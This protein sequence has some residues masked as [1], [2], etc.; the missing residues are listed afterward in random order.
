[1]NAGMAQIGLAK[2]RAKNELKDYPE[3]LAAWLEHLDALERAARDTG[4][5]INLAN[6]WVDP[7]TGKKHAWGVIGLESETAPAPV[8]TGPVNPL[9]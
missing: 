3:L 2:E 7:E 5:S 6:E 8:E 9:D 1:M 4:G